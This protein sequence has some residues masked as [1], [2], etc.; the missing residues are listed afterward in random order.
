MPR[1]QES[2]RR[3]RDERG[4]AT[5]QAV[6]GIPA[7]F[8]LI[9]LAVLG[10]WVLL[11]H[12]VVQSAAADAARAASLTRTEQEASLVGRRAGLSSLDRP[13]LTCSA[14]TVSIDTT[15][16]KVP[17][18]SPASVTATITCK[19]D[20]S[21]IRVPGAPLSRTITAT[22]SSPLDTYRERTGG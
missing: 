14:S 5:L 17:V 6:V 15:G 12:Q 4:S 20:L 22:M 19:L 16:F 18:G 1:V 21:R 10:G 3:R 11:A 9:A 7:F 2:Q 8:V 13:Y